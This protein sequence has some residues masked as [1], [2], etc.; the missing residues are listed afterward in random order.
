MNN[1]CIRKGCFF[2]IYIPS[3]NPFRGIIIVKYQD[4]QLCDDAV[5]GLLLTQICSSHVVLITNARYTTPGHKK[6]V[7]VMPLGL[8]PL[9]MTKSTIVNTTIMFD[10]ITDVSLMNLKNEHKSVS[11]RGNQCVIIDLSLIHI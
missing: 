4:Q 2:Y 9:L 5:S 11:T 1:C 7:V 3:V 6:G 10:E 8:I